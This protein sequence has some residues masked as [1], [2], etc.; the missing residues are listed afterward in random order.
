MP[1]A[2]PC[3]D[4][5]VYALRAS[6]PKNI[7]LGP[8]GAKL[9]DLGT[10]KIVQAANRVLQNTAQGPVRAC[11]RLKCPTHT[12]PTTSA[13]ASPGNPGGHWNLTC[14]IP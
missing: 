6:R 13:C 1:D 11:T 3:P 4:A 10:A 8:G 7:L 9:A 5:A 2:S 14:I 12:H